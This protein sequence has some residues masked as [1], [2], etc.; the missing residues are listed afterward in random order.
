[1]KYQVTIQ[2]N[3][4]VSQIEVESTQPRLAWELGVSALGY[5]PHKFDTEMDI[6]ASNLRRV[7][8]ISIGLGGTILHG[9]VKQLSETNKLP[10]FNGTAPH[11]YDGDS[12]KCTYCN[13]TKKKGA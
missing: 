7:V 4:E 9:L 8:F 11:R 12:K 13:E 3:N 10:H 6:N 1:M 5:A 2:E